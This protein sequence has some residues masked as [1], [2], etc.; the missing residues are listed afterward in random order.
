M[1]KRF[2]RCCEM[3]FCKRTYMAENMYFC[4][5]NWF[6]CTTLDSVVGNLITT[7]LWEGKI[8]LGSKFIHIRQLSKAMTKHQ[9]DMGN[10][11][12]KVSLKCK[13]GSKF[14]YSTI[15]LVLKKNLTWQYFSCTTATDLHIRH[16]RS[17]KNK[18]VLLINFPATP[19]TIM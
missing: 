8:A 15:F 17:M 18:E 1:W 7:I 10:D 19:R 14:L 3:F 4:Y 9:T 6:G 5:A 13:F 16:Q 2:L 11:K 12:V